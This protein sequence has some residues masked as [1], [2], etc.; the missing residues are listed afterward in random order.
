MDVEFQQEL[1]ETKEIQIPSFRN[2]RKMVNA[3]PVCKQTMAIK[4]CYLTAARRSKITT[5]CPQCEIKRGKGNAYGKY[6]DYKIETFRKKDFTQKVLEIKIAIAKRSKKKLVF[7]RVGLP[8]HPAFEP[9]TLD[10]LKWITLKGIVRLEIAPNTLNNWT[11]WALRRW[12]PDVTAHKLRHYRTNHLITE[13]GFESFDLMPYLGWSA[14]TTMGTSGQASGQ[15][16]TYSHLSWRKYFLKLC[17]PI[18]HL[19]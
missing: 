15:L 14:K 3:L 11:K 12:I 8:C 16:D 2:F 1:E 18:T 19:L 13:Y 10:L 4:L 17:V 7:K 5:K 9:W 6:M